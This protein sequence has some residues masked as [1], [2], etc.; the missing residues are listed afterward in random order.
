MNFSACVTSSVG[1]G[2]VSQ[3]MGQRPILQPT[4]GL[5]SDLSSRYVF[6]TDKGTK[7]VYLDK[8][9]GL[10]RWG[11]VSEDEYNSMPLKI[12]N[13]ADKSVNVILSDSGEFLCVYSKDCVTVIEVPWR[14]RN[15]EEMS[16][17]FQ[18]SF[19]EIRKDS[20]IKKVLFHPRAIKKTCM[21][22][23][24]EDDTIYLFD[25]E[26]NN[27]IALNVPSGNIG[28]EDRITSI[29][30]IEFSQDGLTLYVLSA[31][32]CGD[33]YAIYPCLPPILAM[34]QKELKSLMNRSVL[35]YDSLT[36]TTPSA[37][38]K[39]VI[40]QVE[41]IS[42]LQNIS[43]GKEEISNVLEIDTIYRLA[44]PQGPF[45]IAPFPEKLYSATATEICPLNIGG[46][47]EIL[48]IAYDNGTALF[49]FKDLELSMAWDV[50]GIYYNNSLVLMEEFDLQ[51]ESA[52]SILKSF[53][54][55]GLILF[56]VSDSVQHIDVSKSFIQDGD[57]LVQQSSMIRCVDTKAWSSVVS[58]CI[59][60]HDI[61]ALITVSFKSKGHT[62][63]IAGSDI[64]S[65][66]AW[67]HG[68]TE[69]VTWITNKSVTCKELKKQ[70]SWKPEQST[71]SEK[72]KQAFP[73]PEFSVPISELNAL[74]INYQDTCRIGFHDIISPLDRQK[75]LLNPSNEKQLQ[76][77]T[78]LSNYLL[79]T[80]GKGQGL[81][82]TLYNRLLE[83]QLE[84]T[85]Q[86]QCSNKILM[87]Q[88][89]IAKKLEE[90]KSVWNEKLAKQNK[91][92]ERFSSL[93]QKLAAID[94]TKKSTDLVI[95]DEE[96]VWFKE[97]KKEALTFNDLVYKQESVQDDLRF[98]KRELSTFVSDSQ[99]LPGTANTEWHSLQEM[100]K[101]DSLL[102]RADKKDKKDA[103]SQVSRRASSK[104]FT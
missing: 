33:V 75:P 54:M 27:K 98:L 73:K 102:L 97:V 3:L 48:C 85:K 100:L 13:F 45:T 38:K 37:V 63:A 23:L 62:W 40:K 52:V 72:K 89:A 12:S 17:V 47:N 90:Q 87:K 57:L 49:L 84:L 35:L 74:N 41:F 64:T 95:T 11:S 21:V 71:S 51:T 53:K 39:G 14:Y 91:L 69:G 8:T 22:I 80:V 76:V 96:S 50:G 92:K 101:H 70:V 36:E 10:L 1:D 104:L 77:M 66:G 6:T 19:K 67:N 25:V 20:F 78:S 60:R 34:S 68:G 2:S 46:G 32:D 93:Q 30:D 82:M 86:L 79:A 56:K 44:K 31:E 18:T 58:D 65:C 4:A 88:P 7:Y 24:F 61:N 16:Y 94:K 26:D 42:Q 9:N 83:Q 81:G 99:R 5:P 43:H 28:I 29:A 15:P 55:D 103:S 59:D